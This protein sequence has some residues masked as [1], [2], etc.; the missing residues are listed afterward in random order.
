MAEEAQNNLNI[1]DATEGLKLAAEINQLNDRLSTIKD[2]LREQAGG[3]KCTLVITDVGR[4]SVSSPRAGSVSTSYTLNKELIES[5][6]ELKQML[7]NKK[8]ISCDTKM[9]SGAQA[10]VTLTPNV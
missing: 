7:I 5:S 8:I 10:S 3:N 6:A 4:V 9:T 2:K 1:D